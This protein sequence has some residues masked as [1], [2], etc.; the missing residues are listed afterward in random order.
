MPYRLLNDHFFSFLLLLCMCILC[1]DIVDEILRAI[2]DDS[3][4]VGRDIIV[5]VRD[6]DNMTVLTQ[7]MKALSYQFNR[8]L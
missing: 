8:F 7:S 1:N 5:Y 2:I 6:V 3:F 4:D